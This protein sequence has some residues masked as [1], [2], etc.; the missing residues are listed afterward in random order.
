M[1]LTSR[2]KRPLARSVGVLRDARLIV[3]ATEGT[4]TE[5]EYF[6]F[7]GRENKRV[8]VNVLETQG[9]FS[10]PIHV[11]S[12][13]KE[14]KKKYELGGSDE[15]WLVVDK[16]RWPDEQLS[17]VASE[18]HRS[19]FKLAV[20][21]PC[22]ELW[23]YMHLDDLTPDMIDKP[24][25]YFEEKVRTILG[26][27]NP[28]NLNMEQF[29]PKARIAVR[30][31]EALDVNPDERWPIHSGTRVYKIVRTILRMRIEGVSLSREIIRE[32]RSYRF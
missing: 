19:R 1:G 31:A 28:S 20:S 7:F 23:L 12:R 16:D 14:F 3:V 26:G 8:K 4:K 30:R 21:N 29:E 6:E 22:F 10:A 25:S 5:K 24:C 32:R 15:L 27:F 13:L 18:A 2:K 11:L 9:G 17:Q